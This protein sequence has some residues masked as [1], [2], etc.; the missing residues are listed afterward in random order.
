GLLGQPARAVEIGEAFIGLPFLYPKG[1]DLPQSDLKTLLIAALFPQV[2]G[3]LIITLRSVVVLLLQIGQAELRQDHFSQPSIV[4]ARK[5]LSVII[6]GFVIFS[7]S[8]LEIAQIFIAVAYP[9]AVVA[10]PVQ[11]KRLPVMIGGPIPV[12][13]S[14]IDHSHPQQR[15][16]LV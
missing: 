4:G 8:K 12:A 16:S 10:L 5:C 6:G 9:R 7:D 1:A 11:S 2:E 3:L 14:I 15:P 13:Q